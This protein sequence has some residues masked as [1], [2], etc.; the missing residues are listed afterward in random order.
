MIKTNKDRADKIE[1]L[2]GLRESCGEHL[3]NE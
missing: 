2:L 3:E 1:R